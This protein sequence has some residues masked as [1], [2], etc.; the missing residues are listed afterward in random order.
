MEFMKNNKI[1]YWPTPSESPDMN[2][3]EMVW[4]ELKNYLRKQVKPSS[5]R[6]LVDG[7]IKFW[8]TVCIAKCNKY[9]DHV[10]KVLPIV[11]QRGGRASGH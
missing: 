3:V 2:P 4:A 5:K 6:E 1:N 11:I 10:F 7:I 8:N 9:I